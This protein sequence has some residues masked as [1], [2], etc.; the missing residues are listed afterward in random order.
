[1]CAEVN[2]AK[3]NYVDFENKCIV[4]NTLTKTN[5]IELPLLLQVE[6]DDLWALIDK[7][8]NKKF[9]VESKHQDR[10][11]YLSKRLGELSLKVFGEVMRV[12]KLRKS[13]KN[14]ANINASPDQQI[15]NAHRS[16]HSVQTSLQ[17]YR[18]QIQNDDQT[19]FADV[20]KVLKFAQE[21]GLQEIS[22]TCKDGYQ[23][24]MKN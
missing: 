11:G 4:Y 17:H 1:M 7:R 14:T 16:G 15:E 6:D 13:T 18:R 8:K 5:S 19:P 22:F 3:D 24:T 23:F 2:S 21:Q 12:N 10:H 20:I 9:L